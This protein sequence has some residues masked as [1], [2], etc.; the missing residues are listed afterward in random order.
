M[1]DL[2]NFKGTVMELL[3]IEHREITKEK[4]V[5][6]LPVT[7]K[8]HHPWGALHGG[9]SVVLAET[10]ATM[11][12]C[13]NIDQEKQFAVGLEINA[14]HIRSK[15]EGILTATATPVHIGHA[16]SVW[17]IQISDEQGKLICTSRCTL[18]IMD[19]K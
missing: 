12:A 4:I 3:G 13:M 17:D 2:K 19:K 14:S 5:L 11:G 16:V 10:A 6:T 9:V 1:T 7:P 15:R 8:T 18:A